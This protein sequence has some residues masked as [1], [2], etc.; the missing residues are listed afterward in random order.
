MESLFHVRI[1]GFNPLTSARDLPKRK[2]Q[3]RDAI[4]NKLDARD[5]ILQ[6]CHGKQLLIDAQFFL[7]G[8]TTEQGRAHKDMDNLLKIL[9]DVLQINMDNTS[10]P[11]KGLGL[12]DNDTSVVEVHCRKVLVDDASEEG[13]E[14]R[15]Y[16]ANQVKC[17]LE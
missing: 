5:V 15:I 13:L 3:L 14:L 16:D 11:D 1:T 10:E 9:F 4:L 8:K 17:K 7:Y 2:R 6:R 12:I